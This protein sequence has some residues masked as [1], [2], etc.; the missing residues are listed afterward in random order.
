MNR[1]DADYIKLRN[2]PKP[3]DLFIYCKFLYIFI[4]AE[5]AFKMV[6]VHTLKHIFLYQ[7]GFYCIKKSYR[8]EKN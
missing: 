4:V 8:R 1:L 6:F 7:V 3:I 2:Y 5:I